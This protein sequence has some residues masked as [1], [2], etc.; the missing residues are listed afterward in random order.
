MFEYVSEILRES[1]YYCYGEKFQIEF[2]GKAY[3]MHSGNEWILY[4]LLLS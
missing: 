3:K 4:N 1:Q 2:Q